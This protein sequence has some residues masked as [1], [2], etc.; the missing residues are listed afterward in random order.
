MALIID[1]DNLRDAPA[2]ADSA[3]NIFIDTSLRTIKIRNNAASA[4]ANK[5]P[6]LSNDGVTHQSL[7]SFLKKQWRDDPQNKTLI[8]YPFPLV[9]ITPEQFEW[10]YGWTPADDSSRSLIRTGGWREKDENN[11]TVNAEYIGVISLGNIQGTPTEGDAGSINQH[12]AYYA[13]FDNATGA[14]LTSAT[15][16]NYS[17]EVNEAVQTYEN[18]TFD[19]RTEVLRLFIRSEPYA[20]VQNTLA[21]T[22][23]QVDTIDIGLAAGAELPFNCQRFPLVEGQD[24]NILDRDGIAVSDTVLDAAAGPGQKYTRQG[25]GPT[26]LYRATNIGTASL[27]YTQDLAAAPN[28]PIGNVIDA[29]SPAATSGSLSTQELYSWVQRELRADSDIE[30]EA[31]TAKI[32]RLQDELLQFVGPTLITQNARNYD[33]NG[34]SLNTA[35][36]NFLTTDVNNIQFKDSDGNAQKFPFAAGVTITFSNEIAEGGAESKAFVYYEY[37][38]EYSGTSLSLS[39]IGP[40]AGFANLDSAIVTLNGTWTSPLDVAE[41]LELVNGNR[42]LKLANMSNAI[43]N[44]AILEL[45]AEHGSQAF[46]VRT[47]DDVDLVQELTN[48][49]AT[50]RTHPINS[51]SAVLVDSEGTPAGQENLGGVVANL[52]T[53][54]LVFSY[55]YTG[56][57][58]KDRASDTPVAVSVRAIGLGNGTWVEALGTIGQNNNNPIAVTSGIER[59]YANP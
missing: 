59:N 38:R 49:S 14:P 42:H 53:N 48:T 5:G 45:T 55:A 25:D 52:T 44:L 51:P 56:N 24:L 6:E 12:K 16:F 8:A 19:Y 27:G 3:Q 32:G 57:S 11:V 20:G 1:P 7:Y 37:T 34:E 18:P 41:G 31:G 10:S 4:N 35:I 36:T 26:I 21:W 2:G 23:D 47:I 15:N 13:F 54:P 58:Q 40:A 39:D 22:F 29:S 30:K 50:V 28:T 17:G 46:S 9:D 43:N 33:Q